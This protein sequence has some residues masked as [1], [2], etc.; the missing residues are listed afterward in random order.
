MKAIR[1]SWFIILL[2][3]TSLLL[4]CEEDSPGENPFSVTDL[5][6]TMTVEEAIDLDPN[7]IFAIQRDIFQPTCANAGCH[8]GTFEPDFR[9]VA[10]S[11]NTLVYHPIIKNS[12]DEKFT[13]RVVP[14]DVDQS[15]LMARLSYDI[16]GQSGIM[17]LE[18]LDSDWQ[19]SS[20]SY[21]NRIDQWIKNGALD[22]YGRAP[23]GINAAPTVLGVEGRHSGMVLERG[24]TGNG[25]IWVDSASTSVQLFFAVYDSEETA[26]E[27]MEKNILFSADPVDFTNAIVLPVEISSSS[28]ESVGFEGELVK[29][30]MKSDIIL[31]SLPYNPNGKSYFRIKISDGINGLTEIPSSY[32][33]S[34]LYRYFSIQKR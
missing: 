17:P 6:D 23:K 11:Y 34:Y 29:Y 4:N 22:I 16:D 15:V 2:I 21:I 7:S 9:T 13:Y 19:D 5:E 31:S 1:N 32:S 25:P 30:N 10:S 8:D 12:P 18:S 3:L 28:Y 24:D 33:P 20:E 27:L 14:G 26:Q